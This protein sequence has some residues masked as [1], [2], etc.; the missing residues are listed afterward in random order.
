MRL[1]CTQEV[2]AALNRAPSLLLQRPAAYSTDAMSQACSA[3]LHEMQDAGTMKRERIL[4]SAQ[5]PWIRVEGWT[6]EV[7]NFCAL[8]CS[9]SNGTALANRFELRGRRKHGSH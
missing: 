8:T 7:L 2:V 3:A 9:G 5:G 4:T 1:R 6:N